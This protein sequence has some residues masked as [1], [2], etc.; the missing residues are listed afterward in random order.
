MK[1]ILFLP[2]LLQRS[3]LMS[4]VSER[5]VREYRSAL[6]GNPDK[7]MHVCWVAGPEADANKKKLQ[8]NGIPVHP[9]PLRTAKTVAAC[10]GSKTP[11][12]PAASG[13]RT[14]PGHVAG[15]EWV[16]DGCCP[17]PVAGSRDQ[18]GPLA[19]S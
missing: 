2:V 13:R 15:G 17:D 6:A 18:N 10:T 5:V 8:D 9:W 3:A 1:S 19:L 4:E 14:R 7:S 12:I 16:A 11:N